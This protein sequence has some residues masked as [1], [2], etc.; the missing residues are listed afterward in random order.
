MKLSQE[1]IN[2][3]A[4]RNAGNIN[5]P[6]PTYPD[7]RRVTYNKEILPKKYQETERKVV[8]GGKTYLLGQNETEEELKT[9]LA[10]V[11]RIYKLLGINP[12]APSGPE[13]P[14]PEKK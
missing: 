14:P 9:I 2:T 1:I 13:P 5:L 3:V 7:G 11:A 12:D 4:V 6:F 10:D 8:I